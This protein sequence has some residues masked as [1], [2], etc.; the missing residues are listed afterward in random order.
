MSWIAWLQKSSS[1]TTKLPNIFFI[2]LHCKLTLSLWWYWSKPWSEIFIFNFCSLK[3]KLPYS[4][5]F[6]IKISLLQAYIFQQNYYIICLSETFLNST[7]ERNDDMISIDEYNLMRSA[8]PSDSKRGG[9][10]V[11]YKEHVPLIKTDNI[12][13][14]DNSLVTEI[15]YKGEKYFLICIYRSASQ[16]RD[17]F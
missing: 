14:F 17:K 1:L 7:T 5:W 15:R 4:S 8:H 2:Y 6:M 9:V 16:C 13:T 10:C 3:F 11:S 12:S